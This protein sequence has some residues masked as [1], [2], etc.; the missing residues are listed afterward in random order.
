M[1]DKETKKTS[2]LN[3]IA[4]LILV[5][6]ITF[7]IFQL[8]NNYQK[9]EK[10]P[11]VPEIAELLSFQ[12]PGMIG[13]S[14]DKMQD[15]D[16]KIPLEYGVYL[17]AGK[18]G[19]FNLLMKNN[20]QLT[21]KSSSVIQI[22]NNGLTLHEGVLLMDESTKKYPEKFVIKIKGKKVE[23]KELPAEYTTNI[24]IEKKD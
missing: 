6:L 20:L 2:I 13:K 16:L 18:G 5:G 23:L 8:W 15:Y 10:S 22:F 7:L 21:L 4:N 24:K 17:A 9:A 14:L 3:Q 11:L 19:E 12:E 1:M